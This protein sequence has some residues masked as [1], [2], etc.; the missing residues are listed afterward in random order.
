MIVYGK[1]SGSTTTPLEDPQLVR[2]KDGKRE[3]PLYLMVLTKQAAVPWCVYMHLFKYV[4]KGRCGAYERVLT[5]HTAERTA[6]DIHADLEK[7]PPVVLPD[8]VIDRS[9]L[10]D[11]VRGEEGTDRGVEP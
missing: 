9:N 1:T 3:V 2:D 6:L 10:F 4:I 11:D 7:L 8:D 5:V